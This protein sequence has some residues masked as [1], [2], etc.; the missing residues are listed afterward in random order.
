MKKPPFKRFW[1]IW[2]IIGVGLIILVVLALGKVVHA[3]RMANMQASQPATGG[4]YE[5]PFLHDSGNYPDHGT[6]TFTHEVIAVSEIDLIVPM[7]QADSGPKVEQSTGAGAHNIPS[8][9]SSPVFIDRMVPHNTYAVA[10]CTLVAV[11]YNKER[12]LQTSGATQRLDD[13][14]LSFQFSKNFFLIITHFTRLDPT[15]L[16]QL[17]MLQDG[18]QK[19]YNITIE[20]GTLLGYTG[21][22]EYLGTFDFWA[23]DLDS[24]PAFLGSD[25]YNARAAHSVDPYQFFVEP[26]R[27]QMVAKLPDRPEPRVGQYD[28]DVY[29]KLIGNWF[30]EKTGINDIEI[31]IPTLSFFYDNFDPSIILIGYADTNT[32]DKVVGNAPDP[33]LIDQSSGVVKYELYDKDEKTDVTFTQAVVLVQMVAPSRIK[34]ELFPDKSADEV[35]GFDDAAFYFDR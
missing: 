21:G 28:F 30:P 31:R 26:L 10:D 33:A 15:L 7:G 11:T 20:A 24:E 22:S 4:T 27:S 9:H 29:G 17:G 3:W 35:T 25:R 34:F 5:D 18:D 2:A 19:T 14:S 12:W 8:D 32:V 1:Y 13:Y 16:S 23:I 6:P